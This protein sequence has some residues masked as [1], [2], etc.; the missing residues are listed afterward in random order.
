MLVL[1]LLPLPVVMLV[2]FAISK[3][4]NASCG[5]SRRSPTSSAS[6]AVAAFLLVSP[7]CSPPWRPWQSPVL[8][9]DSP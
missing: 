1:L 9:R 5:C 4:S 7:L 8:E 3:S 2:S 6:Y